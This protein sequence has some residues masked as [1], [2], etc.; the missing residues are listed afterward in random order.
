MLMITR[1]EPS[2]HCVSVDWTHGPI[3]PGEQG[4]VDVT[5]A[6]P[7]DIGRFNRGLMIASN[8]AN[9][10]PSLMRFELRVMG[11]AVKDLPA[12]AKKAGSTSRTRRRVHQR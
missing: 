5:Y 9:V 12:P 3:M 4:K 2:C 6:A 8:A 10:D 7:I 1:I 11:E